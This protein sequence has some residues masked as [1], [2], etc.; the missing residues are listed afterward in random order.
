M[1]F[2][3]H[4][5]FR[6]NQSARLFDIGKGIAAIFGMKDND[7]LNYLKQYKYLADC[8]F[9]LYLQSDKSNYNFVLLK[10]MHIS[11]VSW[12]QH[13]PLFIFGY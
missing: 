2:E 13:R 5:S 1:Y 10:P 4:Y 8:L 6:R 9:R 3:N 7:N 12:D 11:L